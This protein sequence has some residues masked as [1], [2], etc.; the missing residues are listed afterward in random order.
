M[1]SSLLTAHGVRASRPVSR[2][3][4]REGMS[5]PPD[6]PTTPQ[7]PY[8]GFVVQCCVF[9]ALW[10]SAAVAVTVLINATL[11]SEGGARALYPF[12]FAL[13]CIVNGLTAAVGFLGSIGGDMLA[14]KAEVR[15]SPPRMTRKEMATL[16]AIGVI[17]GTEIGCSNKALSFL[18][19]ASRTMIGS[20]NVLC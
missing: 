7:R 19:V 5:K 13:T 8:F 3:L 18:T 2:T 15:E 4:P 17:Q 10:W 16:V 1:S 14:K 20:T 12:P 6:T 9:I 11:K